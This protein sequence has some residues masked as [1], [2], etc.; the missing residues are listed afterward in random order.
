MS[1]Q[2]AFD[3]LGVNGKESP[4]ELPN[5]EG[6]ICP[7]CKTIAPF[8]TCVCKCC[9]AEIV[10]GSTRRERQEAAQTGFY[11]GGFGG[12][13]ALIGLPELLPWSIPPTFGLGI[14]S[15]VAIAVTTLG[16]GRWMAVRK[17]ELMLLNPPR[18]IRLTVA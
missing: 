10:Y 11:V 12:I 4:T 1:E 2:A 6:W 16:T 7:Y 15:L 18:F 5:E 14:Y 3:K 17:H 9:Q 8:D 13:F